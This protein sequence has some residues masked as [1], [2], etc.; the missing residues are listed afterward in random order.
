[1]L[2]TG[3]P[4]RGRIHLRSR[5]A[6]PVAVENG[7]KLS[8]SNSDDDVSPAVERDIFNIGTSPG[9]AVDPA[10]ADLH[11]LDTLDA[12][13]RKRKE[14]PNGAMEESAMGHSRRNPKRKATEAA[15]AATSAVATREARQS[16]ILLR[17]ALEP[18]S[19]DELQE[20]EGWCEVE[21]EPVRLLFSLRAV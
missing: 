19:K 6:E 20:W 13:T 8:R 4:N 12:N 15:A 7:Q 11:I 1:M 16:N 14:L 18:I 9:V 3:R 2:G 21:S 10:L 5:K 17:E